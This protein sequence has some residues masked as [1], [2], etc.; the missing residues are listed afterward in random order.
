MKKL[1]RLLHHYFIPH[2]G[3]NYKAKALHLDF[4]TVY[5]VLALIC[6]VAVKQLAVY[7]PGAVLGYATDITIDKLF[8]LTNVERAKNNLPPLSYNDKLAAAA[9]NK[10]QNMFKEN[11]WAHFAPD[12]TTP[13]SFILGSGYQ[14][15]V[16]GENL[17]KG[18]YFSDAVVQAWMNSPS[19]RENMLRDSYKDVGFAIANGTLNGEETTLVVQMFGAPLVATADNTQQTQPSEQTQPAQQAA[20]LSPTVVPVITVA[21]EKRPV[22]NNYYQPSNT[23]LARHATQSTP[24]FNLYPIIFNANMLFLVVLGVVLAMDFYFSKKL[25]IVRVGGKNIAHLMFIIFI[26]LGVYIVSKGGIIQ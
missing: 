7:R 3:N 1:T 15:S 5:L 21:V 22:Q 10:A 18:F 12:G 26:F 19:H 11:Y 17:A 2:E 24:T 16:A 20:L 14:Y 25:K 9:Y 6:T 23:V 13:W 8:Q 4:L